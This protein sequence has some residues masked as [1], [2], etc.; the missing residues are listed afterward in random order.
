MLQNLDYFE[1]V[2]SLNIHKG[3]F[4]LSVL[5]F[6]PYK[7]LEIVHSFMHT[8]HS[9]FASAASIFPSFP[10]TIPVPNT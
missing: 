6:G 7:P 3:D 4:F 1:G 9:S 5:D 2:Q 8:S 10:K